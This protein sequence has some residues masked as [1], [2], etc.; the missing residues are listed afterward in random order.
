MREYKY[1]E[2]ILSNLI[3]ERELSYLSLDKS[4]DDLSKFFRAFIIQFFKNSHDY[5]KSLDILNSEENNPSLNLFE[6]FFSMDIKNISYKYEAL[7]KKNLWNLFCP[8]PLETSKDPN[9]LKKK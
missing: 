5:K 2:K 4:N 3:S 7:S 6:K 1:I 8:E 9:A